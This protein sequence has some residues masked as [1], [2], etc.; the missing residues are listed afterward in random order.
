MRCMRNTRSCRAIC[1]RSFRQSV[2]FES[3]AFATLGAIG[4]HGFRLAQPQVGER[5]AV[6]GLGLLGLLTIQIAAAAGCQV[7]GIDVDACPRA[8]CRLAWIRCRHRARGLQTPLRLSR[9]NRG[10]D[11]GPD[12][13]R[14]DLQ[15]SG[16][17]GGG[18]RTRSRPGRGHWSRRAGHSA[19]ALLRE[20]IV[21]HQF[22]LLWS[23]A[24]RCLVRRARHT[25]IRLGRSAGQRAATSSP[26]WISWP[27]AACRSGL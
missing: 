24:L 15:R 16:R 17:A 11:V 27:R 22:A 7:F 9:A 1:S 20:G 2:D 25:T 21:L 18:D 8:A 4:M 19:A 14:H 3:A 13:R 6:I 12:L 26:S 5:V 10:F 23:R